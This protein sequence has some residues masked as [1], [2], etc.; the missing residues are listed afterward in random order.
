MLQWPAHQIPSR[1]L[2]SHRPLDPTA[3]VVGWTRRAFLR[4]STKVS[5]V[6]S[7]LN[8]SHKYQVRSPG[9]CCLHSKVTEPA[10]VVV[11]VDLP[12]GMC[13]WEPVSATVRNKTVA[14]DCCGDRLPSPNGSNWLGTSRP[15]RVDIPSNGELVCFGL[16]LKQT[17]SSFEGMPQLWTTSPSTL[18]HVSECHVPQPWHV[19]AMA[20][21][22]PDE[23]LG[24]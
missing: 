20:V 4:S 17:S 13:R 14:S 1:A 9:T 23:L 22:M 19:G 5:P 6:Q 21:P 15:S 8:V 16:C 12:A 11:S 24:N 2:G 7:L 10:S 3:A 18:A